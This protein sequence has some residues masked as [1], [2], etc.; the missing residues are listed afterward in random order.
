MQM[1]RKSSIMKASG[2]CIR[3]SLFFYY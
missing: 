2:L 1:N 3:C